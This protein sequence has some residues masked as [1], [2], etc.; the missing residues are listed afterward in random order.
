LQKKHQDIQQHTSS[1]KPLR[2]YYEEFAREGQTLQ[3]ELDLELLEAASTGSA[4]KVSDLLSRNADICTKDSRKRTP[5]HLAAAANHEAVV[6]VLCDQDANTNLTDSSVQTPLHLAAAANHGAVVKVLCDQ[7]ANTNRID[8]RMQT[9][10]HLAAAAN[11]GAIVSLLCDYGAIV[12]L[13]TWGETALIKAVVGGGENAVESLIESGADI[14]WGADRSTGTALYL[15]AEH[16]KE[17]IMKV[18]LE[19][20][21]DVNIQNSHNMGRTALHLAV[22]KGEGVTRELLKANAD[23]EKTDLLGQTPLC[24]A[25]GWMPLSYVEGPARSK[26]W[27][28]ATTKL[29]LE[30]GAI[31][32]PYLWNS[33]PEEFRKQNSQYVSQTAFVV[34]LSSFGC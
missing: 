15:A 20:G 29:L 1:S 5:L 13:S 4:E 22:T 21:A 3:H 31:V 27:N 28:E 11:H 18:L 7:G 23:V 6:K 24:Y 34:N 14:N 32:R 16:G 9:P 26:M 12:D 17:R 25:T 19:N 2:E 30:A 33:M 10:L 8:S